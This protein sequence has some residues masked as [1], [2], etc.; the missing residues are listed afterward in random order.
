[1]FPL[2]LRPEEPLRAVVEPEAAVQRE[3]EEERPE[4]QPQ[5]PQLAE[6]AVALPRLQ[7]RSMRWS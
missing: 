5:P 3:V 4:H 2:L 7:G 6:V 1:L